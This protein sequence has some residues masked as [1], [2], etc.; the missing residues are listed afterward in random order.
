[1]SLWDYLGCHHQVPYQWVKRLFPSP[2]SKD[3]TLHRLLQ[4]VQIAP[5]LTSPQSPPTRPRC[6]GLPH[7]FPKL[8]VDFA[9]SRAHGP[10]CCPN[11]WVYKLFCTATREMIFSR[12]LSFPVSPA[13]CLW[14]WHRI[15]YSRQ[16][17]LQIR[18]GL[19]GYTLPYL[20]FLWRKEF[21]R[22]WTL[23]T[24]NCPVGAEVQDNPPIWWWPL[25]IKVISLPS[26]TSRMRTCT[27]PSV[28]GK[29]ALL[30]CAVRCT[31]YLFVAL[32]FGLAS[33]AWVFTMVL[34]PT[35]VLLKQWRITVL[36]RLNNLL[37]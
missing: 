33:S 10:P 27:S 28:L 12:F 37:L 22:S 20:Q 32:H 6:E 30:L 16:G 23:M 31:P 19:E 8:E 34:A 15:C 35:L 25:V 3:P 29:D 5:G 17:L 26:L 7:S 1:M 9:G 4:R 24:S 2:A 13:G 11:I 21:A 18:R 14:G 36:G